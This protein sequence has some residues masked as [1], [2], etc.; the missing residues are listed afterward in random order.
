[1]NLVGVIFGGAAVW[2]NCTTVAIL[3]YLKQTKPG[4]ELGI[5]LC[6][7]SETTC[8]RDTISSSCSA[9]CLKC[10]SE[11]LVFL[12][13]LDIRCELSRNWKTV[14]KPNTKVI[15]VKNE[16][17]LKNISKEKIVTIDFDYDDKLIKLYHK[18]KVLTIDFFLDSVHTL[19]RNKAFWPEELVKNLDKICTWLDL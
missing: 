2:L 13:W 5:L 18:D 7:G 9:E 8:L 17:F 6:E 3:S 16:P 1:M 4:F 12:S 19:P 11:S 10:F 15:G 14:I